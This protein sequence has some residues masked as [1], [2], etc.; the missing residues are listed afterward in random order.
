MSRLGYAS[1]DFMLMPSKFEPCG[2][3]QMISCIYGSL[4]IVHDTGGLHDT[5]HHLDRAR[6]SGN[7]FVFKTYDAGGLR[8]A[9]NQAMDF[10]RLPKEDKDMHIKRIMMESKANF[11]QDVTAGKYINIYEAMLNRDLVVY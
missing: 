3:P 10:Y 8:W 1:S 2:L 5:V 6:N 4:P 7:G 9:I 11:N